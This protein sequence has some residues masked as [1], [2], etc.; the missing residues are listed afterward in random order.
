MLKSIEIEKYTLKSK[1]LVLVKFSSTHFCK[2]I[3]QP[4]PFPVGE[5]LKNQGAMTSYKHYIWVL[6]SP[7]LEV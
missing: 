6:Y 1:R 2:N 4:C 7:I 3:L 5:T